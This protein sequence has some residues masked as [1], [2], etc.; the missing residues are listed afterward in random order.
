MRNSEEDADNR[1]SALSPTSAGGDYVT[2]P[3][4]RASVDVN[5]LTGRS[6]VS[7]QRKNTAVGSGVTNSGG[8]RVVGATAIT[9]SSTTAGASLIS[10]LLFI[11]LSLLRKRKL[12]WTD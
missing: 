1:I 12:N 4:Q 6:S 3:G 5:M 2:S 8:Q 9:T 11:D 7:G 10:C